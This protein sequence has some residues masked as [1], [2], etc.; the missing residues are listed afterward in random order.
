MA[1]RR[2]GSESVVKIPGCELWLDIVNKLYNKK[3]FILIG[4]TTH[5]INSTVSILRRRYEKINI[6]KFRNGFFNTNEEYE[7]SIKDVISLKPDVVFIAMGSPKQESFI[8]RLM[9]KHSA[10]YMGLGGS[11]DVYCGKIKRTPRIMQLIDLE[12]LYR[13]LM[14]PIKRTKKNLQL[15]KFIYFLKMGRFD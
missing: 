7:K 2:M 5:V 6:L 15:L 9:E 14:E 12:W 13:W 3:T 8:M 10:I 11:L 4:S 1:L